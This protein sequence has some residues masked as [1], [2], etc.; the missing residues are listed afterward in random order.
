MEGAVQSILQFF[1]S[2]RIYFSCG[3]RYWSSFCNAIGLYIKPRMKSIL[4]GCS[5]IINSIK[6]LVLKYNRFPNKLIIVVNII[7]DYVWR[8]NYTNVCLQGSDVKW[9]HYLVISLLE[10]F[11]VIYAQ[12]KWEW[13]ETGKPELWR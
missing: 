11:A 13:V 3:R 12:K 10:T 1:I 6:E 9:Y 2:L 8:I 7:L 4:S 5:N